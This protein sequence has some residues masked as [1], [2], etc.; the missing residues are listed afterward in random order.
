MVFNGSTNNVAIDGCTIGNFPTS[1]TWMQLYGVEV[2]PGAS[3]TNL[4]LV[5]NDLTSFGT[6]SGPVNFN[7]G[8][9]VSGVFSNN[10]PIKSP[11]INSALSMA[12]NLNSATTIPSGS[13][14]Y[15]GN[16]G[17]PNNINQAQI[18]MSGGI[19]GKILIAVSSSPLTSFSY[20]LIVN[21]TSYSLGSLTDGVYLLT[22]APNVIVNT[23]DAVAIQV[24]TG[25]GSS[26]TYHRA[27]IIINP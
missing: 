5:N 1:G 14:A 22:A 15:I 12:F 26:A 20:N 8:S 21:S 10:L 16:Y 13:T 3:V 2:L 11:T 24:F 7:S 9:T 6:G 19:I 17:A 25:S 4:R 23:G 27:T 18:I